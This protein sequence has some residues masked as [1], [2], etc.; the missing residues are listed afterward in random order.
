MEDK[1][2]TTK[3]ITKKNSVRPCVQ[4]AQICTKYCTKAKEGDR[5][6]GREGKEER[7][8]RYFRLSGYAHADTNHRDWQFST[9][10]AECTLWW[11]AAWRQQ[12]RS[13]TSHV[14]WLWRQWWRIHSVRPEGWRCCTGKSSRGCSLR[15]CTRPWTVLRATK[16]TAER[17]RQTRQQNRCC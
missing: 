14:T 17:S 9:R 1:L 13:A 16:S 11:R 3:I 2:K 8:P 4:S 5:R 10:T 15:S 12:V 7:C 6:M